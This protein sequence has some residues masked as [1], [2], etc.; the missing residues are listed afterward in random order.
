[1][2]QRSN[3]PI[4]EAVAAGATDALESIGRGQGKAMIPPM[5]EP[6]QGSTILANLRRATENALKAGA[7]IARAPQTQPQPR[8]ALGGSW[9]PQ[10][11]A[12]LS[13]LIERSAPM[14]SPSLREDVNARLGA[15]REPDVSAAAAALGERLISRGEFDRQAIDAGLAGD[16]LAQETFAFQFAATIANQAAQALADGGASALSGP[17]PELAR[18]AQGAFALPESTRFFAIDYFKAQLATRAVP[19]SQPEGRRRVL[20]ESNRQTL[21][22]ALSA[23]APDPQ[24][25][26]EASQAAAQGPKAEQH[27]A[28]PA[29]IG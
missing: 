7:T 27:K 2:D 20:S 1:M 10:D 8:S 12:Q 21:A 29:K 14:S 23:A 16:G 5:A 9:S 4:A 18:F 25:A 19:M 11:E 3:N 6:A 26:L 15:P 28:R 13:S 22:S 24:S 17:E